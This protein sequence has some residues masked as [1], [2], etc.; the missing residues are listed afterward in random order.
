MN[1][2][3]KTIT[4]VIIKFRR[5]N[6]DTMLLFNMGYIDTFFF[7][8]PNDVICSSSSRKLGPSEGAQ[9]A[10]RY[11]V[12]LESFNLEQ[13]LSFSLSFMSFTFLKNHGSYHVGCFTIWVVWCF[14]IGLGI[15]AYLAQQLHKWCCVLLRASHQEARDDILPLNGEKCYPFS[16]V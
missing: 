3:L 11:H 5:F 16:S 4:K 8:F 10:F 7:S 2:D 12:S 14:L 9:V 15:P 1:K 6:I 13:F